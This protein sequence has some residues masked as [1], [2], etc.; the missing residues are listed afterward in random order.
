MNIYR[1]LVIIFTNNVFRISLFFAISIIAMSFIYTD[2]NYVSK[3]LDKNNAYDRFVPSL[4]ETNKNQSITAAGTITLNDPD[5]QNIINEA[6][7]SSELETHANTIID[8]VYDWLEQKQPNL[9]F[10]VDL[11]ASK[12]RLSEGLAEYAVNRLMS[13]P[14]CTQTVVEIDPFSAECQPRFI[15]YDI[16]RTALI[17]QLQEEQGFLENPI[18]TQETILGDSEESFEDK[19]ENL[20]V[21]YSLAKISPIYVILLLSSLALIVIFASSTRKRGYKKIGHGLIGAGA[22]LIF[23]TF[24]FSYVLPSFTGTLPVLQTSGEGIDALLNDLSINFGRDYSNMIIKISAPLILIGIVLTVYA[25]SE[26]YKKNYKLAKSKSGLVTS[27]EQA[28]K[29]GKS[30]ERPPIQSSESSASKPARKTKNK[31]YR[32]IPKKEL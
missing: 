22:S 12:Q 3:I 9:S 4:L 24:I 26:K 27:N 16:E 8:A 32:K 29:P 21:F 14:I 28:N 1:K 15:N 2:R 17:Q 18:I 5:I 19:Y 23:F 7:P 10:S 20:P 30:N 11:T 6:F 31:K 25:N 13:L